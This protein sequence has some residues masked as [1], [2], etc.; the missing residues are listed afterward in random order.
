MAS[1]YW[2]HL[3]IKFLL[4]LWINRKTTLKDAQNFKSK[5]SSFNAGIGV[6]PNQPNQGN[7]IGGT[8]SLG[9]GKVNSTYNSVIEQTAIRAGDG[10][11]SI[12]VAG[13]TDLKGAI[14]D[15]TLAAQAEGNNSLTTQ[16]LTVQAIENKAQYSA[17]QSSVGYNYNGTP[18]TGTDE[19]AGG[20][21]GSTLTKGLTGIGVATSGEARGTTNS[22][23]ANADITITDN[24]A[25]EA[26]TGTDATQTV[27][28][29]NRDTQQANGS[30]SNP[31]NQQKVAEQLEFLQ[32]AGEVILLPVA[33][34]AAKWIGDTF[35][36]DPEHPERID[37]V[38]LLAHAALGAAMSQ[39][40]G[41]GWQTGAAA[42]ALGDILPNILEKA[43]EKDE[44]GKIKDPD[45]FKAATAIISAAL[46]SATGGDLAQTI[47]A[48]MVTSNAVGE[49]YLSHQQITLKQQKLTAA[50]TE[51]ERQAIIK[52]YADTDAKQQ[53]A[54]ESCLVNSNCDSVM[55]IVGAA[56]VLDELKAS[57]QP[58][59]VCSEDAISNIT[60]IE[61][62]F[63]EGGGLINI[64]EEGSILLLEAMAAE[65]VVGGV[66]LKG[67]SALIARA[68]PNVAERLAYV[69]TDAV[70]VE[71]PW[72]QGIG[73]QGAA[74]EDSLAIQLPAES[75]LP[76]NFKTFD[77]F[78]RETGLATSAKT[79]DTTTA[80]KI[81]N[82]S[83]VYYSL[84]TNVDAAARFT[85]SEL[86]GAK[87]LEN[88][89][90]TREVQVA[91]P[92]QTT[93]AQ[94]EQINKAIAYAQTKGVVLKVT[95]VK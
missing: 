77:F 55:R 13:N 4:N 46:S 29:L 93:S 89:I 91:I 81:A 8:I 5:N 38:K 32:V 31:F 2:L 7:T 79:L 59:R 28:M 54:F 65:V 69:F 76:T 67:S 35:P 10:G 16:T 52:E 43:F 14:I 88:Q 22:A 19:P 1:G 90:I 17:S 15:S 74:W 87:I 83:Q 51:A 71:I 94:W 66:V 73:K 21:A 80:A 48:G 85:T 26:L 92:A 34:K 72:G 57:C 75:R 64:G 18:P 84:K 78:D 60:K 6:S 41:T 49:N 40:L 37:P 12:N 45:A 58:P 47:N 9:S 50:K 24:A 95:K 56:N 11:F 20:S 70:K 33:A 53:K 25:Q 27:A 30:I 61:T 23:I 62:V 82:P 63:N 44:N 39:L 68:F 42:G 36:P 3:R 86:S